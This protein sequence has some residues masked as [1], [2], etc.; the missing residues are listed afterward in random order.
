MVSKR[1]LRENSHLWVGHF[2][3]HKTLWL[4]IECWL[5]PGWLNESELWEVIS[6]FVNSVTSTFF[7][8]S[9]Q[10]HFNSPTI[11]TLNTI[12]IWNFLSQQS[13]PFWW[14]TLRWDLFHRPLSTHSERAVH[15]DSW[16]WICLQLIHLLPSYRKQQPLLPP[17]WQKI[18]WEDNHLQSVIRNFWAWS[19]PTRSRRLLSRLMVASFLELMWM[20]PVFA[21]TLF[22]MILIFSHSW[23]LTRYVPSS[24]NVGECWL[25]MLNT[26]LSSGTSSETFIS[27]HFP[28]FHY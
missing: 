21:S 7:S 14:Q 17:R 15:L 4:R 18:P 10:A 27:P 2:P 6:S 20:D 22:L 11:Y 1:L 13:Q 26:I 24:N 25:W 12:P 3:R 8:Q 19:T 16:L 23:L 28:H 9:Q 5:R